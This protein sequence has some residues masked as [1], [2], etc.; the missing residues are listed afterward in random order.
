MNLFNH[1]FLALDGNRIYLDRH[2][3]MPFLIVNIA[4]ESRFTPQLSRLQS[5]YAL[6]RDAGL[7]VLTI[8]CTDFDEE[9]RN[10][11]E[12]AE[13][14]RENYPH[15]FFV[16]QRYAVTGRD[17]HPL[18]RDMVQERSAAVLP[19]ESFTKYLFDRRGDLVEHWSPTVL[20]DDPGL[21][22]TI[23]QHLTSR[24]L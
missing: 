12:I 20:P 8:P 18:F 22:N 7:R 3:N 15:N 10:E 24:R 17:M 1:H 21:V 6:N 2:R 23:Q 4:T 16:T 5:L 9:P 19:R 13:F 11:D 14:L